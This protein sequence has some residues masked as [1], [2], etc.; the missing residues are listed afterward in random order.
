[1]STT[2]ELLV[3]LVVLSSAILQ[4]QGF[5]YRAHPTRFVLLYTNIKDNL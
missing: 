5:G 4:Y 2:L 1:M 3:I